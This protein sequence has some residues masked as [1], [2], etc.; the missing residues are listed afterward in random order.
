[1]R[2]NRADK[3]LPH[4][5]YLSMHSPLLQHIRNTQINVQNILW[6]GEGS[7]F[8]QLS[9]QKQEGKLAGPY[10]MWEL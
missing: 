1:M 10:S 7:Y 8:L 6:A 5:H 9:L 3:K 4:L 2:G